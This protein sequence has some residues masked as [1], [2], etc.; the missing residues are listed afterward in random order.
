MIGEVVGDVTGVNVADR[1][2]VLKKRF[3]RDGQRRGRYKNRPRM[4][5]IA[6]DSVFGD[7]VGNVTCS[8]A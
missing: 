3:R 8:V 2:Q 4:S 5:L 6:K 1:V 7:V